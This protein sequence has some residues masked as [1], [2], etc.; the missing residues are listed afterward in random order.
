[1]V[2]F[3]AMT[4]KL[5]SRIAECDNFDLLHVPSYVVCEQPLESLRQHGDRMSG[6]KPVRYK[7]RAL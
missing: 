1:M 3:V 7:L 4:K 2:L 5:I 6:G